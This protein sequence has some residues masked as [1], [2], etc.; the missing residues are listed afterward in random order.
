MKFKSLCLTACACLSLL[1]IAAQAQREV[2]A[3]ASFKIRYATGHTTEAAYGC[4]AESYG[5]VVNNCKYEVFLEFDTP[6][7]NNVAHTL[8]VQNYVHG[9]GTTG[10][11]CQTWSYDGNGNGQPG[12]PETFDPTGAQTLTLTSIVFGDNVALL[13]NVPPGQGISAINYNQ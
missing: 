8:S 9:T 12:T 10:A 7:D 6:M 1:A 3:F 5:A 13:C 11:T 4:V 2:T